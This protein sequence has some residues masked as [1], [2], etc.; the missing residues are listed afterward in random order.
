MLTALL[1]YFPF[2]SKIFSTKNDKNICQSQHDFI[3]CDFHPCFLI[4]FLNLKKSKLFYKIQRQFYT[5]KFIFLGYRWHW[6]WKLSRR[7]TKRRW[8][9]STK[10]SALLNKEYFSFFK[11]CVV[12]FIHFLIFWIYYDLKIKNFK[13]NL[14]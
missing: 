14:R 6:R 8:W 1:F 10:A 4:F 9:T 13:P 11:I 12:S 5:Y 7:K 3:V 2:K